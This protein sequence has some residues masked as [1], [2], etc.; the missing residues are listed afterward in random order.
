MN[1]NEENE[2]VKDFNEFKEELLKTKLKKRK[3]KIK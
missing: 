1:I 2:D 3:E